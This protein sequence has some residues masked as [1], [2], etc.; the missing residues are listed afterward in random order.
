MYKRGFTLIELM[1]VVAI[2][3]V[4]AAIAYPSY[5]N[6]VERTNRVD[7]QA[8]M[9]QIALQLQNHH[10]T[11]HN[12]ANARLANQTL[13]QNFPTT[14]TAHYQIGLVIDADEQGWVLTASPSKT[15]SGVVRLNSQGQK[16]WV[17]STTACVASA[18]TSWNTP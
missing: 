5:Q 14:G 18:S 1:I 10:L 6:Y 13:S 11:Q 17:K 15:E 4:L 12:Y 16:C 8:E 7:V 2:I 3:G 9:M